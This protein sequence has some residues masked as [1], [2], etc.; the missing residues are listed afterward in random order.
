VWDY[1]LINR[2]KQRNHNQFVS[3][4]KPEPEKSKEEKTP[5]MPQ[6]KEKIPILQNYCFYQIYD[7]GP[8][9]NYKPVK[10]VTGMDKL[11]EVKIID[12]DEK[13]PNCLLILSHGGERYQ[14]ISI[15]QYKF[16]FPQ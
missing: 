11:G 15:Y 4:Y 5:F 2:Q 14:D 6:E 13:N 8:D 12:L 7:I 1:K 9:G 3:T 16:D 10:T